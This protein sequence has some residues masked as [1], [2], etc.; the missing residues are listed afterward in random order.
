MKN[1]QFKIQLLIFLSCLVVLAIVFFIASN[2]TLN[3]ANVQKT[4]TNE[5]KINTLLNTAEM[6]VIKYE[7]NNISSFATLC[8]KDSNLYFK[9]VLKLQN[10]LPLNFKLSEDISDSVQATLEID[11]HN[12]IVYKLNNKIIW[13][14]EFPRTHVDCI[15]SKVLKSAID[16]T[17]DLNNWKFIYESPNK[18]VRLHMKPLSITFLHND[19]RFLLWT[20]LSGWDSAKL[21]A[22]NSKNCKIPISLIKPYKDS[23][24]DDGGIIIS[25]LNSCLALL[26]NGDLVIVKNKD[27]VEGHIYVIKKSLMQDW[28]NPKFK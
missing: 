12:F 2:K 10:F 5:L 19:K 28:C 24:I 18:S 27:D 13:T 22:V 11:K 17:E 3:P 6:S 21:C 7:E 26:N 20:F 25:N 1:L 14:S 16:F 23:Q 15:E 9:S 4:I 8:N